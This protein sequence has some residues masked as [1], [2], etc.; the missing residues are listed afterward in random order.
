LTRSAGH[1]SVSST[2]PPAVDC[3]SF[4]DRNVKRFSAGGAVAAKA[5]LAA[6]A[7]DAYKVAVGT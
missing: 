7:D 1:A 6:V 3:E 4:S 5:E 2:C